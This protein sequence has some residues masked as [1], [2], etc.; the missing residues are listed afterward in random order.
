MDGVNQSKLN[1]YYF[2]KSDK[3][4]KKTVG[5]DSIKEVKDVK[6]SAS[7]ESPKEVKEINVSDNADKVKAKPSFDTK[8]EISFPSPKKDSVGG[9]KEVKNDIGKIIKEIN[10]NP[11]LSDKLK[12]A[13]KNTNDD[14]KGDIFDVFKSF[15]IDISKFLNS[16]ADLNVLK[17]NDKLEKELMKALF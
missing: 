1:D 15:N 5:K 11:E 17:V 12:E 2:E 6:D 10:G 3:E 13:L 14:N 4:I 8:N 9:P 16:G 7:K